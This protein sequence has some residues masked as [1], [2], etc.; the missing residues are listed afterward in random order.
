MLAEA[1]GRWP[2]EKSLFPLVIATLLAK[3][4]VWLAF[5]CKTLQI[6]MNFADQN[7]I[8]QVVTGLV[9]LLFE[10]QLKHVGLSKYCNGNIVQCL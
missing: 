10:V 2:S 8:P 9:T 1:G 3:V 6:S 7:N 5:L 4:N